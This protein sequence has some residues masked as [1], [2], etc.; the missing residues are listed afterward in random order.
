MTDDATQPSGPAQPSEPGGGPADAA[1]AS[2][3]PGTGATGPGSTGT[4]G[5]GSTDTAGAAGP[6]ATGASGPGPSGPGWGPPPPSGAFSSR[7]GLVRPRNG[8]YL[9]GVCSAIGR[10]TNTDPILWRVLLAVLGFFG[11]IGILVYLVVWLAT[12]SEGDNTSPV[13]GMLGR[14]QSSMSPVT[15]LLLGILAAVMFAFI[16]TDSFRAVL[17][18]SAVLIGGA[19]L[20][21]RNG[22]QLGP[23]PGTPSTPSAPPGYGYG[24]TAYPPPTPAGWPAS[25]PVTGGYGPPTPPT[26]PAPGHPTGAGYPSVGYPAPGYPS[27]G[28]STTGY[29]TT[30]TQ[31]VTVPPPVAPYQVPG[32]PPTGPGGYPAGYRAPFAPYGPYANRPSQHGSMPPPPPPAPPVPPRPP[33]ERSRLGTITFSMI[34]VV[35]GLVAAID[36]TDAAA[37]PPS[38]YFAAV[39][40]TIAA[41]LLVG[42]WFGRARWLIALGLVAAA[43]VG[44]SSLAESVGQTHTKDVTWQPAS[45]D[46]LAER[47]ETVFGDAVLDL[48]DVDF[49]QQQADVTVAVSFGKLQVYLPPDVDVRTETDVRAGEAV[50]LGQRWSGF[51]QP[52]RVVSDVGPDGPG[53]GDLTLRIRISA[54][55]LEVTR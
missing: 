18:G 23:A 55:D 35:L 5:P 53:G 2:T 48:R 7:Y 51:E 50:V 42:A 3:T 15:V 32:P 30:A 1:S 46:Q 38:A 20:L 26:P 37:T 13:E 14:G 31:P 24:P 8:R 41:G 9:A 34:F 36:L 33:R 17:L 45:Y 44:V 52:I 49:T 16:V 19:L 22:G 40:A 10:A 11:G 29:S 47:Y 43:A 25:G 12:P 39:L 27:T 54:G 28:Y 6:D 4:T 21:N